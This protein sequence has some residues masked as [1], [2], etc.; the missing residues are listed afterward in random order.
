MKAP[1]SESLFYIL[2]AEA[3]DFIKKVTLAQVFSCEFCEI[4]KNTFFIKHLRWLLLPVS[5]WFLLFFS[6]P[7]AI[8]TLH[9]K[10]L[11]PHFN[12]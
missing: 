9:K 4:F 8:F 1:V 3:S 11:Q 5:K 10:Q 2:K 6:N 12:T 7:Q